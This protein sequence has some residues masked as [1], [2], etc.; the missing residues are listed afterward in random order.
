MFGHPTDHS[1]DSRRP[2]RGRLRA[3]GA[4]LALLHVCGEVD[5]RPNR[6]E[7]ESSK[8]SNAAPLSSPSQ[9]VARFHPVLRS[10]LV[11]DP[12]KPYFHVVLKYRAP[13]TPHMP[14]RRLPTTAHA[15]PG[16]TRV[17]LPP[18]GASQPIKALW[19]CV[20]HRT[21]ASGRVC[22]ASK[23]KSSRK[24]AGDPGSCGSN[25]EQAGRLRWLW[26]APRSAPR[27]SA[28]PKSGPCRLPQ[29]ETSGCT[30]G[31]GE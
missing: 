9:R 4:P 5:G 1:V 10:S 21:V 31:A 23:R 6:V 30:L 2:G 13:T 24:G 8:V 3:Q 18:L 15:A 28:R 25:N 22:G 20:S 27:S 12:T 11:F 29:L 19:I 7:L 14:T 17:P 26:L 16:T